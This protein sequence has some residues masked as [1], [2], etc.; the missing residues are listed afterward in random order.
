MAFFLK[1]KLSFFSEKCMVTPSFL[2]GYQEYLLSTYLVSPDSFKPCKYIPVLVSI[3][4]RKS[5][6]LEMRR[7][8]AQ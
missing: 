6:Y 8:Y 2:F 3:G 7:T 1:L 5:E 4:D